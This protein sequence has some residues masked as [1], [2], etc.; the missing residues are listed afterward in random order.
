MVILSCLDQAIEKD[1][2][3]ID[4]YKKQKKGLMDK[5]F[6]AKEY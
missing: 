3:L 1:T 5:F 6:S 2:F 4:S